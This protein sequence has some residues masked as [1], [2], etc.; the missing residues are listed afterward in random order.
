MPSSFDPLLSQTP[1]LEVKHLEDG[2]VSEVKAQGPIPA[3]EV[4]FNLE[5]LRRHLSQVILAR[6]V[7]SE[8]VA[9]R[10]KL[11]EQSVYNVAVERMKH[12]AEMLDKV[13]LPSKGLQ[14]NNLKAWMWAWH[15]KLLTRIQ[16]ELENLIVEER[17]I[18]MLTV[19]SL[20]IALTHAL[21]SENEA[22]QR[23]TA[24]A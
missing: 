16:A 8:D 4:P 6:R 17:V 20:R 23:Q 2:T 3:G 5:I 24:E 14:S 21:P 11:L 12:Q 7:L 22:E 13:G 1:D 19:S 18:G 15:Q 9:L 10:Q